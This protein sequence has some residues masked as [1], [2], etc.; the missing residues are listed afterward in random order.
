MT[1]YEFSCRDCT[2]K[3]ISANGTQY[4][5]PAIEGEEPIVLHG[6]TKEDFRLTCDYYT[7]EPRTPGIYELVKA[8]ALA[9]D[10]C[11]VCGGEAS[12]VYGGPVLYV[13][14]GT[15]GLKSESRA[16]EHQ[17]KEA[18]NGGHYAA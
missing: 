14:C 9:L 15:C 18:W 5:R 13:Q 12:F 4:C 2:N 3:L 17:T 11:P 6:W 7:T 8:V 10:P 16:T 1:K